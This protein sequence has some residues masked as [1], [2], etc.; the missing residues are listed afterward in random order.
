MKIG[1]I[2]ALLAATCCAVSAASTALAA[3]GTPVAVPA[4]A[5]VATPDGTKPPSAFILCDGRTGHVG[6]GESLGRLIAITA[7]AGLSEA[8]TAKDDDSKRVKGAAAVAACD[9]A[10][11]QETDLVRRG[12]LGQAKAIH[13]IEA[14]RLDDALAAVRAVPGLV[15]T[16]TADWGYQH[17]AMP[18]VALLEA[19]I[20]VRMKRLDEAERAAV[21]ALD[22]APYDVVLLQRAAPYLLLTPKLY[23]EKRAAIERAVRVMPERSGILFEAELAD[24]NLAAAETVLRVREEVSA[25]FVKDFHPELL[26]AGRSVVL[27][28][29]GDAT[30][31]NALAA[32]VQAK[33]AEYSANGYAATNGGFI[34]E[35]S[36][37]LVLQAILRD[38]AE[39]HGAAARATFRAHGPFLLTNREIVFAAVTKLRAGAKDDE[40]TGNLSRTADQMRAEQ[41]AG[42]IAARSK[43]ETLPTLYGQAAIYF[44]ASAYAAASGSTWKVAPKPRMLLKPNAKDP[45]PFEIILTEPHVYGI[46]A[47]EAALLHAALIAKSRGLTGFAI[48]PGRSTISILGVRFG[49]VGDAGFP[50]GATLAADQVIADISPYIPMPVAH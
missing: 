21:R 44:K 6:F 10:L 2:G 33:L 11:A 46:P 13:L 38:L 36:E 39:G 26:Q 20:L 31:S 22:M 28:L 18:R 29:R 49:N 14:E 42:I 32:T 8:A 15:G 35:T 9:T 40:L 7:T 50:A 3:Q 4:P 23:P 41:M 19:D 27:M 37:I 34:A 25:P 45:L 43:P 24:G 5:P 12:Q 17:S 47:G 30:Q 1:S 48:K 16:L